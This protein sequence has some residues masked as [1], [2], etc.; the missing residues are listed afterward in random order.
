MRTLVLICFLFCSVS[1][2]GQ[3]LISWDTFAQVTMERAYDPNLGFEVNTA[4]PV[5]S[6]TIL[7]LDGQKVRVKGY[8]IPI[9]IDLNLYMVSAN[10]FANCFFCGNAGPET[11]VELFPGERFRRFNT[12]EVVTF[13]GTLNINKDASSST[14]PYQMF[15]AKVQK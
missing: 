13:V 14:V 4:P 5:Y 9:D 8:V 10:P 3:R 11:V 2:L 12:D 15:S 6:P 7:A 1:V